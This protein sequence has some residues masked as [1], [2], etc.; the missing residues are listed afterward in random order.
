VSSKLLHELAVFARDAMTKAEKK[1]A[2][3]ETPV[4]VKQDMSC[5][6]ESPSTSLETEARRCGTRG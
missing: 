4:T 2:N 1:Q 6:D 3:P 5:S